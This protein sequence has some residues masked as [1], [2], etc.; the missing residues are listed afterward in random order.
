MQWAKE[1]LEG[2][3]K[4]P[5]AAPADACGAAAENIS[6]KDMAVSIMLIVARR[7]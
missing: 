3:C 6:T 1:F 7:Q 4:I 2:I 5:P